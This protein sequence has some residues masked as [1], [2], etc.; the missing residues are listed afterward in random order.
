MDKGGKEMNTCRMCFDAASKWWA[1]DMVEHRI[2]PHGSALPLSQHSFWPVLRAVHRPVP[3]LVHLLWPRLAE[4][5][6]NGMRGAAGAVVSSRAALIV[7]EI[8]STMHRGGRPGTQHAQRQ[9][10]PR[11]RSR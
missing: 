4:N 6:C 1:K 3:H 9:H 10:R 11:S 5:D 7:G 2:A 8:A